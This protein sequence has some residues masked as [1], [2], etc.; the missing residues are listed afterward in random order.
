MKKIFVL[1]FVLAISFCFVF[2][3]INKSLA[4]GSLNSPRRVAE[5][6]DTQDPYSPCFA[7]G[8][9]ADD[10]AAEPACDTQD[11]YSPCFAP[12]EK[13][14]D[15][16]PVYYATPT[17]APASVMTATPLPKE[18]LPSKEDILKMTDDDDTGGVGI[19]GALMF[20]PIVSI[21]VFFIGFLIFIGI[22]ILIIILL[23]RKKG[24]KDSNPDQPKNSDKVNESK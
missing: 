8:E 6:C 20:S 15:P 11:P 9:K 17:P 3:G 22:V 4:N 24:N 7:P 1:V 19:L 13:A 5:T 18:T 12:G 21:I 10:S 23:T 16:T 2:S 14:D